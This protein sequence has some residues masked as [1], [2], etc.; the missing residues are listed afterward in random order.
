MAGRFAGALL[1]VAGLVG[2]MDSE[3]E[4]LFRRF[5]GLTHK[6][7]DPLH[8]V[9]LPSLD[10][11]QA[12]FTHLDE[13][14]N[15]SFE[16]Q[17][18]EQVAALVNAGRNLENDEGVED[19]QSFLERGQTCKRKCQKKMKKHL[20]NTCEHL[21]FRLEH[22]Q[23]VEHDH[24]IESVKNALSVCKQSAKHHAEYCKWQC[25]REEL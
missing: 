11:V 17:A 15:V 6:A 14:S 12:A 8:D 21:E 9:K 5:A 1:L 2:A 3:V 13:D 25:W 24:L 7:V 4:D 19:S 16:D 22:A 23:K 18:K 10:G 20:G